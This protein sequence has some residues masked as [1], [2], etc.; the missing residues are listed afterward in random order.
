MPIALSNE[1]GLE[2]KVEDLKIVLA[3]W[4]VIV[5]SVYVNLL[6]CRGTDVDCET[7][8]L[9]NLSFLLVLH[10][11][12]QARERKSNSRLLVPTSCTNSAVNLPVTAGNWTTSATLTL[13]A[14]DTKKKNI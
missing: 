4:L 2:E 14:R 7:F 8:A 5:T 3:A 6:L 13:L 9:L 1:Q 12:L 11:H 10:L